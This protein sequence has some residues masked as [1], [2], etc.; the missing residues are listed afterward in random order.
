LHL[1]YHR[2][3]VEAEHDE[4]SEDTAATTHVDDDTATKQKALGSAKRDARMQKR[5]NKRAAFLNSA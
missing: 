4:H 5:A 2:Q 3:E 1:Q